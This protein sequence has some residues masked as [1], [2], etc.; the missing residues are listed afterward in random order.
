MSSDGESGGGGVRSL[1]SVVDDVT[2]D[3][4][5]RLL[6]AAALTS[7]DEEN[8][9][10]SMTSKIAF[11][12]GVGVSVTYCILAFLSNF[13]AAEH[14]PF[15]LPF[16]NFS[17]FFGT[18]EIFAIAA[19]Y[20]FARSL[21]PNGAPFSGLDFLVVLSAGG[22]LMLHNFSIIAIFG[23]K[24]NIT[25]AIDSG[26]TTMTFD[27]QFGAPV[28]TL[29]SLQ[30][31]DLVE[32]ILQVSFI[33]FAERVTVSATAGPNSFAVSAFKAVLLY[34]AICNSSLWLIDSFMIKLPIALERQYFTKW[35]QIKSIIVTLTVFFRFSSFLIFIRAF[36]NI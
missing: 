28:G 11:M 9:T 21:K 31:I 3:E 2:I 14:Q 20:V 13:K 23:L 24:Q 18:S 4:G 1:H 32:V 10:R 5:T 34:L 26:I 25:Y 12:V 33:L 30:A 36:L 15:L 19:G 27:E 17:H 22:C 35:N 8:T 16:I 29:L 7:L 6:D